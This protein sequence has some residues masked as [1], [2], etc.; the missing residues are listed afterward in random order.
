MKK[1]LLLWLMAMLFVISGFAQGELYVTYGDT[2]SSS[3]SMSQSPLPGYYGYHKS[4]IMYTSEELLLEVGSVITEVSW[5]TTNAT[6]GSMAPFYIYLLESPDDG[7]PGTTVWSDL[8]ASATLV[9]SGNCNITSNGWSSFTLN[10]PFIYNGGNLV[11]ITVGQGCSQSGGC[12]KSCKYT[13]THATQAW[14][15]C[16][17]NS[18]IPDDATLATAVSSTY[19]YKFNIRLSYLQGSVGC[20]PVSGIS[21]SD[22]GL[23]DATVSWIAP[24]DGGNYLIQYKTS[25]ESWNGDNVMEDYTTETSFSLDGLLDENTTYNVR[26]ANYCGG[27]D[28]SA[29]KGITFKTLC[30]ALTELPQFY[31]FETPDASSGL[32]DCWEKSISSSP[33]NPSCLNSSYSAYAGSYSLYFSSNDN[34][35]LLPSL[36]ENFYSLSNLQLRF[37]LRKGYNESSVVVGFMDDPAATF[38]PYDTVSVPAGSYPLEYVEQTVLLNNYAG[39]HSR[40]ALKTISSSAYIDNLYLEVIPDCPPV[41]DITVTNLDAG[42]ATVTWTGTSDSYLV[43]YRANNE[44]DWNETDASV[45]G[46]TAVISNLEAQTTY[47][48]QIAPDCPETTEES[49]RG[50]TFTTGCTAFNLPYTIDFETASAMNCWTVAEE[51][52]DYYYEYYDDY[53]EENHYPQRTLYFAHDGAFC[54]ALGS[55]AGYHTVWAAPKMNEDIENI[56]ME[57]Y[58]RISSAADMFGTL[59]VGLMTNPSDTATFVA[60][61]TIPLNNTAYALNVVNFNNTGFYG[62]DYYIAFRYDGAGADADEAGKIYMDDIT[63]K[64]LPACLEPTSVQAANIT[65]NSA[66]ISWIS[67]E[68][69][70]VLYYQV[71]GATTFTPVV[72]IYEQTYTLEELTP[73]TTYNVKVATLCNDGTESFSQVISFTTHCATE[74]TPYT[75]NFGTSSIPGCWSKYIGLAADAFNGTAPTATNGGWDFSTTYVFNSYHP[76]LNIYGTGVKYWLVSPIIDLA[77]LE[78]PALTFDLA[79]TAYGSSN[80]ISDPTS[81]LDDKFM[82]IISTDGGA[83]WS[84]ANATVW[85]NAE[86]ADHVYNQIP[87]NGEE[88]TLPLTAYANQ[89]I[90]IAFYGESTASGGDN[91][92]HINNVYVGEQV[93]CTRPQ[94]LTATAAQTTATLSWNST[95]EAFTLYYKQ[96]T[97]SGWQQVNN[98]TLVNGSYELTGLAP[99]TSYVWYVETACGGD[100]LSSNEAYFTTLM[101]ANTLP[102]YTDFT[103]GH[104]WIMNNGSV[105][106]QWIT[107]TPNDTIPSALFVTGNGATAGY[108]FYLPAT[109]M[110]EKL[111]AMPAGDSVHVEFDLIVGGESNNYNVY[112]YLKVFLSPADEVFTAGLS[113]NAQS[114]KGNSVNAMDFTADSTVLATSP[115]FPYVAALSTG[116]IHISKNMHIPEGSSEAK[117]V[118][119]WRNDNNGGTAPGAIIRN[120]SITEAD[121]TPVIVI[122]DPTV[123]TENASGMTQTTVTLNATITNPDNVTITA[124][125]FEWRATFGG[126]Y[127]TVTG[128]GSDNTFTANLTD[129]TAA[130]SYTFKAFITFN[131]NTV[132]GEEVTFNT[133]PEDVEPC[134]AP[135]DLQQLIALKE[136]GGINIVWTD[137]AGVTQWNLQYRPLNGEWVPVVVTGEPNYSITGLVNGDVYEIRV[138]AICDGGVVSE[139]SSILTA[140]ASNS[141]IENYIENSITLFP[142]PANDVV[143]VECTMNNVQFNVTGIEV[144]DVYGKLVNTINV[145][146]NPTR[147][148][149]SGLANGMYFVRVSTD[150]GVVTKTF[151][152]K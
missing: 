71:A 77:G 113:A 67:D 20:H 41:Q 72:G 148:N 138:Q 115:A 23:N 127:Q 88:V 92:L 139:W 65:S 70:F 10:T 8:V 146:E 74:S 101:M 47:I 104:G 39:P 130:T 140:T 124:K 24:E 120:F 129:L 102:Y 32:P 134:A 1:N 34:I 11:V 57:F 52:Y 44:T 64:E 144:Y 76:K 28:T 152:K 29:W 7:I 91:D 9:Y 121:T 128:T 75:E 16:K 69:T 97:E 54:V 19:H 118:F 63:I 109:V 66:D 96:A 14:T 59:T 107:G 135:T 143:N 46:N 38:V 106:N 93:A 45:D 85:S 36:D 22:I 84:E 53:E 151:V 142:N 73:N 141:G 116:S 55:Q 13:G 81:Q 37:M 3:A 79:L 100:E 50:T 68:S 131:G 25:T 42:S 60:V 87:Y 150:A 15:F 147:I 117:I 89:T 122:T 58:S 111:F 108:Q 98:V 31:D 145:V 123:S 43:R 51:G 30:G 119:L 5:Q 6:N 136:V 133:L 40:I 26:V 21:V 56:R 27:N 83:T 82:V 80:P 62:S 4:A 35:A 137:N 94:G 105:T 95:A 112:D 78:N 114:D 126:S 12:S 110:A 125:G 33:T 2:T 48:V 149:V 99:A 61:D 132:Y 90:R 49:Y 17:D 18:P 86:G 103:E